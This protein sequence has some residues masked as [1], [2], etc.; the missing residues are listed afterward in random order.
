MFKN[1]GGLDSCLQI[2]P[3]DAVLCVD[4]TTGTRRDCDDARLL[5]EKRGDTESLGAGFA[6][7]RLNVLAGACPCEGRSGCSSLRSHRG[8]VSQ[9]RSRQ[10]R[11]ERRSGWPSDG[12][13]PAFWLGKG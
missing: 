11:G 4:W 1:R 10:L 9:G 8:H 13:R 12:G 3:A 7:V 2:I 6:L 5:P